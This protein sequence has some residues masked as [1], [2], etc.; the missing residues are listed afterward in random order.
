MAAPGSGHADAPGADHPS[1]GLDVRTRAL[2]LSAHC[3]PLN[4]R[5]GMEHGIR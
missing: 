2:A 5:V 3:D 4:G 1:A